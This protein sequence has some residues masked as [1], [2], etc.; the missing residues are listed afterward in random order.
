MIDLHSAE[1]YGLCTVCTLPCRGGVIF[2]LW[3]AG[4]FSAFAHICWHC[5][6][7]GPELRA[8]ET[9]VRSAHG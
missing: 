2:M 1:P 7:P 6:P 8:H 9:A 3:R 5:I 4:R